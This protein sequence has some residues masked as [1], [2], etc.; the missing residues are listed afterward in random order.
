[1]SILD[2]VKKNQFQDSIAGF[3]PV[4]IL[5]I[6]FANLNEKERDVI[7]RRFGLGYDSKQTLEEIGKQYG[8]TRERVRQIENLSIKKLKELRE[9]RDEIKEAESVVNRLLEQYGGIMEESFFLNNM[10][11]YLENNEG[12]DAALLFLT[13]HIFSDNI[14]R[15]KHSDDFNHV[16]KLGSTDI[17]FLKQVVGEMV[18]T[19][20]GNEIPLTL[21]ELLEKF[22]ATSFYVENKERI[23][24]VINLLN[25]TDEDINKILESYLRTSTRIKQDLFDRWGLVSWGTVQPKKINDK[26]YLALKK[27][28]KP[29]HFTEIAKLINETKFDEKIA[30]PATVH[31]EL[32]LDDK[33]VLVGR[34]IY[35][36]RE[37]GYKAGRVS[38]VIEDVLRDFNALTKDEII[39]KVLERRNVKKSTIYLSLMNNKNIKKNANG[40]YILAEKTEVV[41]EE[42]K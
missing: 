26:I 28:G 23:L 4:K 1:M 22:K 20:E 41:N 8:I 27:S 11:N 39:E 29:L 36:L 19:I 24:S 34:G 42:A 18:K 17:D 38:E 14:T 6:L 12:S 31:N 37:W 40:K 15:H 2:Q 16:W 33:Y 35:A 32:I 3:N 30:Y 7:S 21:V 25:V 10:L 5:D 9:L 13:E